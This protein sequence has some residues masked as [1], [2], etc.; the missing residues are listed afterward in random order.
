MQLMFHLLNVSLH[1]WL[2]RVGEYLR[3]FAESVGGPGIFLVA[4]GDSSFLSIPEGNDVL[5]VI[6]STGRTWSQ[7]AYYVGMTILGSVIGCIFLFWVGRKGGS[8]LLHKRFSQ[9]NIDRAEGLF[10]KYGSWAVVL[11]SI[12]PPPCPFKIFVLIAGV[13]RMSPP[14][15]VI[16]VVIGRT[17]RYSIWGILAVVYGN[18]VKD[19]MQNNLPM[20]GMLLF[21]FLIA[22]I[23][24]VVLSYFRRSRQGEQRGR[25]AA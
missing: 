1:L 3:S 13:F 21:I 25:D 4:V 2:I 8:P 7:M 11:P 16:S 5:I 9:K 24:L 19:Y 20:I 23:S 12:L 15:F 18:A 6:L 22:I 10:R 17:I 14:T